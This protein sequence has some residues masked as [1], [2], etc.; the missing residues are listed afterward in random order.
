VLLRPT[1]TGANWILWA[2]GPAMLLIAG[3]VAFGFLR[4]RARAPQPD[5][6]TL[7]PD[8]QERLRRIL[9]E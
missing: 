4:S 1:V 7:D 8:E 6:A 3:G 5:A 2:A 9:G